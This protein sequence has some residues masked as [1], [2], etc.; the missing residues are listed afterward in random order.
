M[1]NYYIISLLL[2]L[3]IRVPDAMSLQLGA[4]ERGKNPTPAALTEDDFT[5]IEKQVDSDPRKTLERIGK[6]F[7]GTPSSLSPQ[8]KTRLMGFQSGANERLGNF[9]AGL[10]IGQEALNRALREGTG[11]R[12]VAYIYNVVGKNFEG[13]GRMP[14]A[15]QFYQQAFENFQL[16]DNPQGMASSKLNLAGLFVSA[17]LFNEA[18]K[19][20]KKALALLS[21]EDDTFLYT[22]TLNN[23]GFTYVENGAADKAV[24]YLKKARNI[25][26]S[27]GNKLVIAYTY[28]NLGEAYY[29]TGNYA[30]SKKNLLHALEIAHTGGIEPLVTGIYYFLGLVDFKQKDYATSEDYAAK[31]LKMAKKNNDVGKL[32]GIYN[33]LSDQARLRQEYKTALD[34]QDL[35]LKYDEMLASKN[36]VNAL[37][38]L[39]TEFQLKERQQQ[40]TLLQRDNKIQKLSLQKGKS[41]RYTGVGLVIILFL[42]VGFLLYVLHIKSQAT[43]LAISREKALLDSKQAAEAANQ[44]KS[45]FLS[46]MSHEL[47][48]PLNAVI[49]F[50]ETL[51]LP[52]FGT[53]N[54]KQKEFVKY[55]HEGG[56]LLLKL[57][58]DLLH[59]SKIETGAV[60]LELDQ[61]DLSE[62]VRN[63]VPLVQHIL[64][65]NQAHLHKNIIPGEAKPVMIDKIRMD[66]ILV[67]LISNAV[68]YGH[69]GGNV[70]LSVKENEN[71][72][73]RV[74]VRDDGLGIAKE[75]FE[76]VF[77]PF[78]RAGMEQSG[79]EG[80]GAGLSIVKALIEAMGGTIAFDSILGEGTTFW[81]DL[82]VVNP[83]GLPIG[84][85]GIS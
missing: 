72:S 45:E 25:A 65:K 6:I 48:T 69:P 15:M 19:E 41:L 14:E 22:R 40:I 58:N 30:K 27:M 54:E 64:E 52:V 80:T 37:S 56:T 8:G 60:D 46:Y 68:K 63:V 49:G 5:S 74:S 62:I 7:A 20:Y 36:I 33:L 44:A 85:N 70:W 38:L 75:Q 83:R 34:Y 2:L 35:K 59:L 81:I 24:V 84:T 77:T 13:L 76:N 57:I 51:S 61:Y 42:S 82:P 26:E 18:I 67:N 11:K 50:S 73:L 55:I 31:A 79:I 47:R 3:L 16:A 53:L 39:E 71:G 12:A 78:N 43:K 28:E 29:H 23:L 4:G 32:P 9:K 10:E 1:R 17:R 21:P 66:Q